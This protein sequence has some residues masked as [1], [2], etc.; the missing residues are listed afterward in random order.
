MA[1]DTATSRSGGRFDAVAV[2]REL[3]PTLAQ[4]AAAH[5]ADDTFVADSYAD[6]KQRKLF[7]AGIPVEL[8]GGGATHPELCSML[9]EIGRC[10]G[11]SALALSMHTHLV[12]TTVWF[13]K[14][15]ATAVEPLLRRL[16][17]EELI[18]VSSGGSDWLDGSGKAEK[19]DGGFR[20]NARKVFASG[21]PSGQLL[22]TTALYDDPVAGVTVL[23]LPVPLDGPGIRIHDNWRT[24]GMRAT[25]SNDVTIE[26]VFVPDEAVTVRRPRGKWHEFFDVHSPVVWPLVMSVYVGVAEAARSLALGQ[27]AKKRDDPIV[28]GL[29]GEMDTNLAGA[30]LAL[31]EMVALAN[32][33]DYAP[34][35]ERSNKVYLYKTIAARSALRAVELAMEVCGGGSF[36][37]SAGIERLFRDIQGV[38]FHP[39]QERKQYVF[40]G[41]IALGLEPV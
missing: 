36:F 24:M 38:R 31:R 27:A 40:S 8:G 17:A 32:D 9:Q 13:W 26:G 15:G 35:I 11:S 19:V 4:R 25:G 5:D 10:C 7:S 34:G 14:H 12:A 29:V 23:H 18:L 2:A 30:Q 16:A 1:T 22:V 37:R 20:V 39:W 41:R 33:Y 6:F 3:G 28:Q 21:S